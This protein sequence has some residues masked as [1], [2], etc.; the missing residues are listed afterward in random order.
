MVGA[1]DHWSGGEG[2][3]ERAG[4]EAVFWWL[5][6]GELGDEGEALTLGLQGMSGSHCQT[7]NSSPK[8][9]CTSSLTRLSWFLMYWTTWSSKTR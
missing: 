1:G 3:E 8:M 6:R 7:R 5:P 9:V 2:G 4:G